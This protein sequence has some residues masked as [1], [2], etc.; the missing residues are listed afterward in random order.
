MVGLVTRSGTFLMCG[1]LRD[2]ELLKDIG[3]AFLGF[4]GSSVI[5][6]PLSAGD[7]GDT[8]LILVQKDPLE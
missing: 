7:A 4:P 2:N 8:G 3:T 6:N 5:E 1:G